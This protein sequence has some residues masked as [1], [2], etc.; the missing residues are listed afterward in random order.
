MFDLLTPNA[1]LCIKMGILAFPDQVF[2]GEPRDM[3]NYPKDSQEQFVKNVRGS[4]LGGQRTVF[5][6][7]HSFGGRGSP[8]S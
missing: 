1:S 6:L 4:R 8:R 5:S 7:V 2:S 3:I